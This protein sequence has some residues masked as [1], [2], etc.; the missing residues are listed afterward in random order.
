MI[1]FDNKNSVGHWYI[2]DSKFY[3]DPFVEIC[4]SQ[5]HE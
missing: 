3:T 1:D 4:V 2:C 5:E